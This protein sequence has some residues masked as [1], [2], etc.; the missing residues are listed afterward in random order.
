VAQVKLLGAPA[1]EREILSAC[2]TDPAVIPQVEEIL[3]VSDL[4][5]VKHQK[6]LQVLF[7]LH[8]HGVPVDLV[9]VR[10]ELTQRGWW[11]DVGAQ[12][13]LEVTSS[14]GLSQNVAAYCKTVAELAVRR[15]VQLASV[16]LQQLAE[17][18]TDKDTLVSAT[19]AE[20]NIATRSSYSSH[21]YDARTLVGQYLLDCDARSRLGGVSG[22]QSGV[23]AL[24]RITGPLQPGWLV[25]VLAK[26]GHGKTALAVG[27]YARYTASV[28][29]RN[30]IVFSV[31]MMRGQ[32]IGR[33]LAAES[34]VPVSEHTRPDDIQRAQLVVAADVVANWALHIDDS[35]TVTTEQMLLRARRV[36]TER[37]GVGLVVIDYAQIVAATDPKASRNAQLEGVTL[38]A[39]R[40][41]KELRCPV[42]LLAQPTGDAT[43]Q[44][45]APGMGDGK[46]TQAFAADPDVIMS[47]Y[48]AWLDGL[49]DDDGEALIRVSKHRHGAPGDAPCRF[50]TLRLRF[51]G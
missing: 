8:T 17:E 35:A 36:S 27:N 45:R 20:I 21:V 46:G 33:L 22:P 28:L 50:N 29:A 16:R 26:P 9:T 30:V 34:G 32:L 47:P 42:L 41:A 19:E 43:R 10:D 25:V 11:D 44:A 40:M 38:G 13:I 6:L 48:R 23:A 1:T 39:K 49:T 24:D 31:E 18:V 14:S 15:R 4:V 51:T 2:L 3:P 7:D 5:N 37:G 12:G